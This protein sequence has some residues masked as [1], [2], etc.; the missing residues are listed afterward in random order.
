MPAMCCQHSST[1][2]IGNLMP[3]FNVKQDHMLVMGNISIMLHIC[4]HP[5]KVTCPAL[6]F[7]EC[8]A[9]IEVTFTTIL[10]SLNLVVKREHLQAV[11]ADAELEVQLAEGASLVGPVLNLQPRPGL[12]AGLGILKIQVRPGAIL[13]LWVQGVQ[14]LPLLQAWRVND[15]TRSQNKWS[16]KAE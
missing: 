14:V 2:C 6:S 12:A 16:S 13:L 4:M 5:N 8:M 10:H 11:L 9:A 1:G 7:T 15:I 3:G